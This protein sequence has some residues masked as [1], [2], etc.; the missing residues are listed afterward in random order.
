MCPVPP[1][2]PDPQYSLEVTLFR[3]PCCRDLP[4][5]ARRSGG[6][7]GLLVSGE[8]LGAT[9]ARLA[10]RIAALAATRSRLAMR[11][12]HGGLHDI[13]HQRIAIVTG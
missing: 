13:L 2:A 6:L 12:V 5:S 10:V 1:T 9:I 3:V 8:L 4:G 11:R 7:F